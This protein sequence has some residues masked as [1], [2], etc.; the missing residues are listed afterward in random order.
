MYLQAWVSRFGG[1]NRNDDVEDAA[2]SQP[3]Y[4]TFNDDPIRAQI[5]TA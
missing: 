1:D 2:G 3:N 4:P 5:R